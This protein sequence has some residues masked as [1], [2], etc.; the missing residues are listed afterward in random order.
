MI[1]I[2]WNSEPLPVPSNIQ[3]TYRNVEGT[4][5]GQTLGGDY[6]KKVIARK[7]D[8]LVS[9]EGLSSKEAETVGRLR[10]STYGSLT[11][12]SPAEGAFVTRT[13]HI[14]TQSQELTS[15]QLTSGMLD[16]SFSASVH[17]KQR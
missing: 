12:Y 13:M 14:E 1:M 15:A 9:W 4:N 5:S 2:W 17:F 11:F 6:S 16:G 7:E 8:L 3:Y 10:S